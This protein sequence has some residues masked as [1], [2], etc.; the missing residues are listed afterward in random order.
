MQV[1]MNFVLEAYNETID[2]LTNENILLKA[3]LKQLQNELEKNNEEVENLVGP[4]VWETFIEDVQ[5]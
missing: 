4:E 2:R 3:Q 5:L 1:D